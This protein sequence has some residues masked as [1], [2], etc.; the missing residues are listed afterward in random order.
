MITFKCLLCARK[1]AVETYWKILRVFLE[2]STPGE[3]DPLSLAAK[4]S[5]GIVLG[6]QKLA[7]WACRVLGARHGKGVRPGEEAG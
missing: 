1:S 6:T 4:T 2:P 7:L 5:V 3:Q